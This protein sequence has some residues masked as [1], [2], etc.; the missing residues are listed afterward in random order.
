MTTKQE[1]QLAVKGTVEKRVRDSLPL[2]ERM[3]ITA[4]A[5]ERVVLN[6][7]IRNPQL[8]G[9]RPE[10]LGHSGGRL[11]TG[12]VAAGREAGGHHPPERHQEQPHCRKLLADDGGAHDAG[13]AGN[14]GAGARYRRGVRG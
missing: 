5:Y 7:L 11:H 6:A 14:A 13:T 8:A 4:E 12:G 9:L 2:L 3:G 10:Q 1:T